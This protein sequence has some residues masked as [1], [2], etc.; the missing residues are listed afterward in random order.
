MV[1]ERLS[2]AAELGLH[3]PLHF[4]QAQPL[5]P[6]TRARH[7]LRTPKCQSLLISI[8]IQHTHTNRHTHT[9]TQKHTPK[10][11]HA[12]THTHRH[13]HT[14]TGT[15]TDTYRHTQKHRSV[16]M[17]DQ[18]ST[19][20]S[21]HLHFMRTELNP[22]HTHAVTHEHTL[23]EA[24]QDRKVLGSATFRT[25]HTHT[26]THRHMH[27]HTHLQGEALQC[28]EFA[29]CVS[30]AVYLRGLL[31]LLRRLSLSLNPGLLWPCPVLLVLPLPLW[32][33]PSIILVLPL[34]E[35]FSPG[36]GSAVGLKPA[37]GTSR[38]NTLVVWTVLL[39][40][41]KLQFLGRNKP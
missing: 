32:F 25:R 26:H 8:R 23:S 35:R 5:H 12:D 13:T 15:H 27:T 28:R 20:T 29:V 40:G 7:K 22:Q 18:N 4:Q 24:T 10:Q 36:P 1:E 16:K 21:L 2:L 37:A 34:S 41:I 17:M 39:T 30:P 38:W 3:P 19:Q 33:L 11:T 31:S 6:L 14:R 9:Q